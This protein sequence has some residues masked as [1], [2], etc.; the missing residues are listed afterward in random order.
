MG[1]FKKKEK[2]DPIK[3]TFNRFFEKI[4]NT[5]YANGIIDMNALEKRPEMIPFLLQKKIL[6]AQT[7]RWVNIVMLIFVA[8]TLGVSIW[9][10]L[11]SYGVT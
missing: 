4:N 7:P 8:I 9:A 10:L 2:L 1:L 5:L 6:D 3:D 11:H